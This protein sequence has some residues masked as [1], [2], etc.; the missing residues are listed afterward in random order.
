MSWQ[1]EPTNSRMIYPDMPWLRCRKKT[2]D[3]TMGYGYYNLLPKLVIGGRHGQISGGTCC[4]EPHTS[5]MHGMRCATP[6]IR[7]AISCLYAQLAQAIAESGQNKDA[8]TAIA[9]ELVTR[10]PERP[11]A[12]MTAGQIYEVLDVDTEAEAAYREALSREDGILA[13][14]PL[15]KLMQKQ[16]GRRREVEEL[17]RS[18]GHL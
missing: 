2:G 13:L 10:F 11:H 14:P 15:T 8:T 7:V 6:S 5:P 4:P 3:K 9:L 12:W 17:V 16:D 1:R 18:T